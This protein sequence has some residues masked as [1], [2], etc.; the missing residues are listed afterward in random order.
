MSH[1]QRS[2]FHSHAPLRLLLAP[3]GALAA[4]SSGASP[5]ALQSSLQAVGSALACAGLRF[6]DWGKKVT[7]SSLPGTI[8]LLELLEKPPRF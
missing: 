4:W 6:W 2:G 7:H 8:L 5:T 1:Q 3:E